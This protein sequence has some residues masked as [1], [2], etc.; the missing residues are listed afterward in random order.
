MFEVDELEQKD[1]I[2]TDINIQKFRKNTL[3]NTYF[4]SD[5]LLNSIVD[6][7]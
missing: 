7:D 5:R 6:A 2:K 1:Y 4:V 3:I